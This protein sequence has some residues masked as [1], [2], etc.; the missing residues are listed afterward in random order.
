MWCSESPPKSWKAL[1]LIH[2]FIYVKYFGFFARV[3]WGRWERMDRGGEKRWERRG[4]LWG[5]MLFGEVKSEVRVERV[6]EGSHAVEP[7]SRAL[8]LTNWKIITVCMIIYISGKK[9]LPHS[10]HHSRTIMGKVP[11]HPCRVC[12]EGHC[13]RQ[14]PRH[15]ST[16]RQP[17]QGGRCERGAGGGRVEKAVPRGVGWRSRLPWNRSPSDDATVQ[18]TCAL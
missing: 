7:V 18:R 2:F 3:V 9:Q 12:R 6:D 13:Q 1:L 16:Q 17:H 14:R 10:H 15:D 8:T 4:R 5:E 11:R